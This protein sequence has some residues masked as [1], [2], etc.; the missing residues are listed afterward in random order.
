M[1]DLIVHHKLEDKP[2]PA[3]LMIELL[4]AFPIIIVYF[5]ATLFD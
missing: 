4:F 1:A 3:D 5:I 2:H